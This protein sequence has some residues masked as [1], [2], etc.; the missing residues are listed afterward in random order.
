MPI[1]KIYPLKG[2]LTCCR[3]LSVNQQR[4]ILIE[5]ILL[6]GIND[7]EADA[8]SLAK[9][10]NGFNCKINLI[11]Y[12][13]N[14]DLPYQQ[15]SPETAQKFM[16]ILCKAGLLT[17]IRH[18]RGNDISAACGQLAVKEKSK[19]QEYYNAKPAPTLTIKKL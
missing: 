15:S 16:D 14:P 18:S 8:A 12:N 6:K 2:L 1:N 4:Q 9:H 11:P 13:E 10:L 17:I 3:E 19:R 5:Y 7:S